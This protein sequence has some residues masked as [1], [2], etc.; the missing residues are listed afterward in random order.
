VAYAVETSRPVLEAH[1]H[2][3]AIAVPAEPLYV[4]A[5]SIRMA[6]V[7]SNLLNNAAKYTQPG[8]QIRLAGAAEGSEVV[9]RV[10][11]N[12]IGI[13]PEMLSRIFD[14]FAQVD[15]SLDHSQGG[16]GL[17]LTLVR[18]LVDLHG[19]S[20]EACSDGLSR[21][22]EFIVRL[23]R[24]ELSEV[25]AQAAQAQANTVADQKERIRGPVFRVLV[26]D[27][28]VA[29]AQSLAMVLKLDGHDV[30]VSHDGRQALEAVRR[31]RPEVVLMD[32]G[33]PGIDG[34]EVARRLRQD[35]ELGAGIALLAAVTGYAEDEAR[36]R[37]R[38]A[39]FD[40]HLVKP[41]DPDCVLSLLASLEWA[42][43][44]PADSASITRPVQPL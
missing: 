27:D 19:G 43:P 35:A 6:Q 11:D 5:D 15:H 36:R 25:Q 8:G 38:E 41:V 4:D 21:G 3:L 39:G 22:S 14:L 13:P 28:N 12:G 42:E 2:R 44:A 24:I 37:S 10:R 34:Y 23:P 40:H 26:V 20:V 29:S 7:L 33:L 32:I 18:S 31:F 9:F 16:L 30:E 17:G 1:H